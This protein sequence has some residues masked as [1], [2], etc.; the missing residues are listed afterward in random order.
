MASIRS[1][2]TTEWLS[3]KTDVVTTVTA[4]DRMNLMS[5]TTY[6]T[7][8]VKVNVSLKQLA[9]DILT[10]YGLSSS[11]YLIDDSLDSMIVPIAWFDRM[12]H[13]EALRLVAEAALA[14][15]YADATGVIIVGAGDPPEI[16]ISNFSEYTNVITLENPQNW[17]QVVNY[18]T[19]N[20]SPLSADAPQ[21]VIN[22]TQLEI[23]RAHV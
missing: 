20:W 7:S 6:L 22:L 10:D 18:V 1:I 16:A 5:K 4:R 12:S 11:G 8:T 9:L 17:A 23:G 14:V 19:V 3:P 2:L 13:R 21:E 15:V